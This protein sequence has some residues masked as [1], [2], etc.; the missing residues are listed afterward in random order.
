[1][2]IS[3]RGEP[4]K[5]RSGACRFWALD[6][7]DITAGSTAPVGNWRNILTLTISDNIW[8]SWCVRHLH[9]NP[10]YPSHLVSHLTTFPNSPRFWLRLPRCDEGWLQGPPG[11]GEGMTPTTDA[12][13]GSTPIS[14]HINWLV[15][16]L[17]LWKIWVRQL[18]WWHSQYM[19]K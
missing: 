10:H 1:M 5:I 13:S 16:N 4:V 2:F 9:R 11:P 8:Q 7:P 3:I 12:P 15:V 19:E 14:C 17:P 6:S 18:G